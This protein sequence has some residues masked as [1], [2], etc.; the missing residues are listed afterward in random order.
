[1]HSMFC[2]TLSFKFVVDF[3]YCIYLQVCQYVLVTLNDKSISIMYAQERLFNVQTIP[4][5]L[6]ARFSRLD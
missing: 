6:P 1:M 4:G 3:A 5:S 2:H